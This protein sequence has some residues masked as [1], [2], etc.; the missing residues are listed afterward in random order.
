MSGVNESLVL[1]TLTCSQSPPTTASR[2]SA[3]IMIFLSDASTG[4]YCLASLKNNN[5]NKK[6][7]SSGPLIF[8][9]LSCIFDAL[10]FRS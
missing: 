9:L 3:Y 8:R 10:V 6:G 5:K 7:L 4:G 1:L 2:L